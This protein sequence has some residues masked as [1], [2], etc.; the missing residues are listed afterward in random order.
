MNIEEFSEYC[1]SLKGVEEKFPFGGNVLVFYVGGKMFCLT[2]IESFDTIN[3]KCDP[4]RAVV[5]REKYQDVVPGYHMNKKHWNTVRVNSSIPDKR[6]KEWV[7]DSY[8][9]V[10]Q[11]LP[12]KIRMGMA[13]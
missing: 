10:V 9:L 8:Q 2:D 5:L 1:L 3:V 13:G 12:K 4:E 6:I 7:Y 11:G